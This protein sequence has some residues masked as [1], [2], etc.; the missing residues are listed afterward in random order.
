MRHRSLALLAVVAGCNKPAPT[1]ADVVRPTASSAETSTTT[2][3]PAAVVQ[4]V[5]PPSAEP[6][7]TGQTAAAASVGSVTDANAFALRLFA[8]TRSMPGNSMQSAYSVRTALAMTALG[9]KGA[10]YNEMAVALGLPRAVAEITPM[11]QREATELTAARSNGAQLL[12]ANNLFA[13]RTYTFRPDFLANSERAFGAKVQNLDFLHAAE[14]GRVT[15]NKWAADKTTGKITE[16]VPPQGVDALTRLVLTNAVYFKAGWMTAF[17]PRD[18][19]TEPFFDEASKSAP[20]PTMHRTGTMRIASAPGMKVLELPYTE[21][22]VVMD[23]LLPDDRNG[24]SKLDSMLTT[25]ALDGWLQKLS[26]HQVV[27]SLPKFD[28]SWGTDLSAPLKALGMPLAFDRNGA[29]FTGMSDAKGDERLYLAKVFHKSFIKLDE[30]GTEAAAATA[31]VMGVR[32]MAAPE[33]P[34]AFTADHPFAFLIRDYA[35]GRIY[36]MGRVINPAMH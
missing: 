12:S 16:L 32:G 31:A 26:S 7:A 33:T 35:T 29:D 2:D 23:I 15:I 9:G 6:V 10:T 30:Q 17:P 28:F 24:L 22:N 18:T 34:I 27:L 19:K 1:A 14:A 4:V 20:V 8:A 25:A 3:T 21:T 13:E 5:V 36:F 11:A